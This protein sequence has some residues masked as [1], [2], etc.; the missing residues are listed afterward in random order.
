[1]KNFI[2]NCFSALQRGAQ[3]I[4]RLINRLVRGLKNPKERNLIIRDAILIGI[5]AFIFFSS[6]FFLW[7]SSLQTPDLKSFDARLL[8]QSAKIYDRTGT[9]LLYDLSQRVRRTTVDFQNIS[10]FVKQATIAIEDSNFYNHGGIRPTSIVRAI[11]ADIVTLRFSQGGSTI[12]QQVVKNS[13]LTNEKLISRKLKEWILAIKLEQQTDKDSILNL[14]LNETSY[15]GSIYGIEEASNNFFAK[16]SSDL[17][18]AEAAYLAAIPQAPTY[19]SPYGSHVEQLVERKNLVLKKMFEQGYIT[20]AQYNQAR[21]EVV[22]F[23]PKSVGSIKAP[24]F[25]MFVREYLEEKYGER[26]LQEGGFKVIT[27]LDYDLQKKAEEIV[28]EYVKKNEK[29]FKASNGAMVAV[30]PKSGEILAMVGSRDYFDKDIQGNFNVATAHRQPGSSFKPFVYV[31]AFNQGYTPETPLFDVP[32]EFNTGCNV[33][34]QPVRQGATCYSPVNYEGGYK[35]LMTIRTALGASRNVPAV[36]M[37]YLVGIDNALRT[38]KAMGIE[39]LGPASQYGLSLVL[40]GGEVSLLDMTSAYGVFANDGIRNPAT[41]ILSITSSDGTEL[42]KYATSSSQVLPAQSAR[43]MNDVLSDK[44]ARNSIFTLGYTGERQ[45]AIKTGTTNNSRDAWILGYTPSISVGAWMGN[46]NNTPMVQK[47]SAIIVA[48]MWKQFMDYVLT[49]YP[50]ETFEKP[51]PT[52]PDLKPY[53]KGRW[54]GPNGEVHS[55]LYWINKNDPT[56]DAPSNPAADPEFNLWEYGV[57]NW[58]GSGAAAGLLQGAFG[59]ST[60]PVVT[61]PVPQTGTGTPG[62]T[63]GGQFTIITPSNGSSVRSNERVTIGVANAFSTTSYIEYY[64]NGTKIGTAYQSPFS[65]SFIPANVP[66]I[67]NQAQIQ[68][69][70]YDNTGQRFMSNVSINI[71]Q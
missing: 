57:L 50:N 42:E 7:A 21:E 63:S 65:Y 56:G 39:E 61:S 66:N 1:M 52:D 64:V 54:Y 31:T 68:A 33:F 41:G 32:T 67:G 44:Y 36:K 26:M 17:T 14:Y 27:T 58:A 47:A 69:I 59:T 71:Q 23:Q 18:L 4:V 10:P 2:K 20:E 45:V 62:Q 13:L 25:V 19:F 37:L 5:V 11:L 15:G 43:L 34:G 40:G 24:H 30:D 49:K 28:E 55:E 3:K 53:L 51:D 8:G 70:A 29:N 12:T 46:N 16:K 38:A 35:G 22:Q 60:L 48:P 9:I 6:L